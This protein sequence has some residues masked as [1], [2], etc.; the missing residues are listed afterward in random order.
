MTIRI[1][2]RPF[3]VRF[4]EAHGLVDDNT[5]SSDGR[6]GTICVDRGLDPVGKKQILLHEIC[7]AISTDL[8]LKLTEA[9]SAG[10]GVGL[11]SIRELKVEIAGMERTR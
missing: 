5:G 7:H 3:N 2:G 9:Q 1:L 6:R 10:L 11:A 8:N 4:V